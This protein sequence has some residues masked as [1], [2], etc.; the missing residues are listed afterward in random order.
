MI[1]KNKLFRSAAATAIG[2]IMAGT[3]GLNVYAGMVDSN[4]Y[5]TSE[6]TSVDETFEASAEINRQLAEESV[7]LLKN[8]DNTLPL[9][10][11]KSISVFGK[12]AE[13]YYYQGGG[14]GVSQAFSDNEYYSFYESLEDAGFSINPTLRSFYETDGNSYKSSQGGGPNYD[15]QK[16]PVETDVEQ[17]TAAVENSFDRYNDAAIIVL[18]RTGTEGG[19]LSSGEYVLKEDGTYDEISRHSLKLTEEEEKLVEYVTGNEAFD[20][21]IVVLNIPVQFEYGWIRDNEKIDAALW[22]GHPGL[23][24]AVAVGEALN[25]TINPSGRLAD[26]YAADFTKD[27]TFANM[28]K[29][30]QVENGTTRYTYSDDGNEFRYFAVEYEEGIY[31]GYKYYETRFASMMQEN[32]GTAAQGE[33]AVY[34]EELK[35]D[36]QQWYTEN[37]IYPFGYGGSYTT[38]E[39]SDASFTEKTDENGDVY[40]D[41]EVTVTNTG[42]C[43]GKDVVELYYTAPYY[44][45][46]VAKSF[47]QLGDFV[48]TKSLKPGQSQ[49]VSMKL[50]L[51]DMASFDADD[52]NGNSSAGYE[53]D[54][55]TY[56]LKLM[57]DSHNEAAAPDGQSLTFDFTIDTDIVYT[58]DRVTGADVEVRFSNKD[59]YDT[60]NRTEETDEMG[61]TGDMTLLSR[62]DWEGTWPT[63]PMVSEGESA[64]AL[65]DSQYD[66]MRTRQ[67]FTLGSTE[68]ESDEVWYEYYN[69]LVEEAKNNGWTQDAEVTVMFDELAGIPLYDEDGS[70]NE[71]WTAYMNQ[72]TYEEMWKMVF[73]GGYR[74]IANERMGQPA[75]VHYDGPTALKAGNGY[76][77]VS[78][79]NVAA[80]WNKDLAY[81]QGIA[82]GNEALQH[83]AQGW[84]APGLNLH[85]TP[86]G[87][88]NFEYYGEDGTQVGKI[89]A[90]VVKGC[91]SKGI[92]AYI[93]HFAVNNQDSYRG[94][95]RN[96]GEEEAG[97]L[98]Y[99]TEQ[100]MRQNYFKAFQICIEEGCANGMMVSMN[101]IGNVGTINNYQLCTGVVRNEWGMNGVITT[102]IFY[103]T[104]E[105][106][107]TI[108]SNLNMCMRA[109][110]SSTLVDND[111]VTIERS[112]WDPSN[113]TVMVAKADGSEAA[114]DIQWISLRMGATGA[115]YAMAN[116]NITKNGMDLS[117][118]TGTELEDAS[119]GMSYKTSIAL[120]EAEETAEE[121]EA[122]SD[123]EPAVNSEPAEVSEPDGSSEAEEVSGPAETAD[124]DA[125]SGGG[126]SSGESAGDSTGGSAGESADETITDGR[127]Y[128]VVSGSLPEGMTL[129]K[130]GIISGTSYNEGTYTFTVELRAD[131]W[132]TKTE[133]FS[134]SVINN[135]FELDLPAATAGNEYNGHIINVDGEE[136]EYS[137]ADGNLPSGLVLN[138]DGSISGSALTSGEY[139]FTIAADDGSDVYYLNG[140]IV[141]E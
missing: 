41:V 129:S 57:R 118:F 132:V 95:S 61:L 110:L 85:R 119:I 126:E 46:E 43:A 107:D 16:A 62:D 109:G 34:S 128:T 49:R 140:I 71:T 26:I 33:L 105:T 89:A 70:V 65:T 51:Q 37:V 44:A 77:W 25:G 79:A 2:A 3:A 80:A 8:Q 13:N 137:I 135:Y 88:R 78:N 63:T 21:V 116:S 9:S 36:A 92:V 52:D 123:T 106:D 17:F 99:L 19:D 31:Y 91:Q 39:W 32:Y 59:Q 56:T 47:V 74:T 45:G 55:G 30:D 102:D 18:G 67:E 40:Y 5:F 113:N 50:Y 22:V 6:Y 130:G 75:T 97:L 101:C 11:V 53:L 60:L 141:I 90:E 28:G 139:S 124:A 24:G 120:E 121:Q 125:E 108:Y 83:D 76:Q 69:S 54:A 64:I 12:A 35:N 4:G 100:D 38:F 73:A 15:A 1:R 66:R 111:S 14:S 7:V 103:N 115:V 42:S 87:G 93:K 117:G 27:P 134:I 133:E 114:N 72:Y 122:A 112:W 23:N 131:G 48:K 84:Y 127:Y 98:T 104:Q 86:F 20:T 82:I 96:Q 94:N 58:Q 68:E 10:G 136:F 138:T 29:N 81:K